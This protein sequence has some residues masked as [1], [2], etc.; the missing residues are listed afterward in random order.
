MHI[1]GH[2]WDAFSISLKMS[3]SV[4]TLVREQVPF[5]GSFSFES[6]SFSYERFCTRTVLKR[7]HKV[8]LEMTY[9]HVA[10]QY[11]INTT[12]LFL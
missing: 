2:F 7:I 8:N 9:Y 11:K 12:G 6:N 1:I 4:K 3:F 10:M 5:T